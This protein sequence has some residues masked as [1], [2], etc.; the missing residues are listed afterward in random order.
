MG[1]WNILESFLEC[2]IWPIR[3][4]LNTSPRLLL[5]LNNTI[6]CICSIALSFCSLYV[7]SLFYVSS[8]N[9]SSTSSSKSGSDTDWFTWL[10][11][12]IVGLALMVTCII[13]IRGAHVVSLEL[14]L[15]YFWAIV[16]F[17]AP[18][19]LGVIACF[20]FYQYMETY[21]NHRWEL[22]PF[23]EVRRLFCPSNTANT[24]CIAPILGNY[25]E[26][27]N[28]NEWCLG[29]Y[30]ATDCWDIRSVAEARALTWSRNIILA[31]GI[32][33]IINLAEIAASLFLCYR[34]LTSPV[35]TQSMNDI[36]N[37][38]QLIP[39]GGCAGISSYLSWMQSTNIAYFWLS[40]YFLAMA[41][42]QSIEIPIGIYAGREKNNAALTMYV[43]I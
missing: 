13:G 38:L 36:I 42:V 32:V 10:G 29:L 20:D 37:Y 26:Y 24:K 11:L 35:I 17:I 5:I 25:P 12:A 34:I 15:I 8:A 3:Y 33:A 43:L 40:D 16:V 18:L 1:Y 31:E 7:A 22:A 2:F 27:N 23:D 14:L 9:N 28:V 4:F 41:V 6:I 21:F 30:N 19:S 39:I